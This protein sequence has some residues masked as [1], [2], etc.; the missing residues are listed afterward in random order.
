MSVVMNPETNGE[1]VVELLEKRA[2]LMVLRRRY[3]CFLDNLSLKVPNYPCVL[4]IFLFLIPL[5]FVL[6][7]YICFS[8]PLLMKV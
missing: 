5:D 4:A 3:K 1:R 8:I 7:S 2:S 6:F